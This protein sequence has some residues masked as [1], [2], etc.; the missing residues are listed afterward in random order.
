MYMK[1]KLQAIFTSITDKVADTVTDGITVQPLAS[2]TFT[3][4]K[5]VV[6]L[7]VTGNS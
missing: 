4:L 6:A 5:V 2:V 7:T 3:T 1:K